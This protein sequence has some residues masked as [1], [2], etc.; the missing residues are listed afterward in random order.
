MRTQPSRDQPGPRSSAG[1]DST[2]SAEPPGASPDGP[3]DSA[4]T[5]AFA[6]GS[7]AALARLVLVAAAGL[8]LAGAF[9]VL[10]A[11]G[12]ILAIVALIMLH[13]LGHL[14]VAKW[15]GMKVTEYYLGFGPRLW[16]ITRGETTYGVKAIPAGGYVRILGM[17]NLE[18]VAPEDEARTFRQSTFPR[19]LGV[20]VAGSTVHFLLALVLLWGLVVFYGQ[21]SLQPGAEVV[22]FP[23]VAGV[24]NPAEA[25][26]LRLGDVIVGAGGARIGNI[27]QLG[28][29]LAKDGTRPVSLEVRQGTHLE[30]LVVHP[31]NGRV[32]H[33]EGAPAL[34]PEGPPVGVIGVLI[35]SP[36]AVVRSS[37]LGGVATAAQGFG[38]TLVRNVEA[39]GNLFSP[40]GISLYLGQ[41]EGKQP[42]SAAAS[43]VRLESPIG[44]ARL[45]SQAAQGGGADVL[46]LLISI[47]IFVGLFNMVP[48][49]PLDGGRVAVVVYERLRSFRGRHYLADDEKLLP[50][51]YVVFLFILV[52][53]IS[54]AYLDIVHPL[55][56]PFR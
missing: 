53:G 16:S 43:Q 31:V 20:A 56:N 21:A 22:G 49:L 3:A 52:L 39:L 12:V 33:L 32:H 29:V 37:P 41:L 55:P 10:G 24:A 36:V 47:N 48:L 15:S 1:P 35:Q 46:D 8:V 25:A 44:V 26:G 27:A 28:D 42:A 5:R 13:E 17:S 6:P 4:G 45:A 18:E 19:K 23:K 50:L 9:H 34:A 7:R 14:L 38:T 2:T 51:T 40:H 11:V 54:A 30:H